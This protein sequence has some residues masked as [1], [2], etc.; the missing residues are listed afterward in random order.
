MAE[1]PRHER[2]RHPRWGRIPGAR[3]R[4]GAMLVI[5]GLVPLLAMASSTLSAPGV[6]TGSGSPAARG[7]GPSSSPT[8]PPTTVS[9]T[10][11]GGRSDQ[12]AAAD[13]LEG[14][15]LRGTF[16][17][18][19]GF[20]GQPDFMSEGD[21]HTLEAAGNEIGGHTVSL[22]DLGTVV[23][24]E[25]ARQVCLDRSSLLA[26][27]FKVSS[28]A[29]PFG[30]VTPEAQQHVA[31]CGYNS[32]RGGGGIK[33][34]FGCQD[35]A[36]AETTRPAD[37]FSTKAVEVG[38]DWTLDDLRGVV[39]SAERSGGWLQLAFA[40]IGDG[41]TGRSLSPRIFADFVAWLVSGSR[42][43]P[44]SVRTVHE[45]IGGVTKPSVQ[46]PATPPAAAGRNALANPG[47]EEPGRYGLPRCWQIGSYGENAAILSTLSPGHSGQVA[48]RL[49]VTGYKSGD[50]KLLPTLDLGECS[51]SV[52]PG[53]AYS[54]SAWYTSTA[55][56]QFEF[57]YRNKAG[58][59]TYWT[60]SPWFPA[61]PAY[62]QVQ[63]TTPVVPGDAVGIS[64]GL[65][66]FSDGQLAT[67]D[68]EM[69]DAGVP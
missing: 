40:D 67:D 13:I 47:L 19:S 1:T 48:R 33:S 62:R 41:G 43:N 34:P 31:A 52:Q 51:P 63:W 6:Q 39:L 22:A 26:L 23:G 55:P 24:D 3:T 66:L 9:L 56:T 61:G 8:I 11:D 44:A 54:V 35:C 21:L 38:S 29:Y 16:F 20:L 12:M 5:A 57:Y 30:T 65:N 60:A 4:T 59:W 17:V 36:V 28:F 2:G 68:Y 15:G 53:H 37:S 42:D 10:F 69:L 7:A 14:H 46:G 45:V 64:F 25:A 18:N 32:G 49:D 27:G 58:T 50:A